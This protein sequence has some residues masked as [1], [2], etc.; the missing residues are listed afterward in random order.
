MTKTK[1]YLLIS[2]IF[3]VCTSQEKKTSLKNTTYGTAVVDEITSIYDGDTFRC[4]I[5]G[6]P[7]IVGE[8]I[9]IRIYGIDTPEM[10]DKN[11]KIKALAQKAKQFAVSKLRGAKVIELRNMRRGKFFRIVAEV[12]VDGKDLG[13]MM[14]KEGLA[15]E[16]YGGT[17]VVWQ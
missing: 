16:Y 4:N 3:I 11:P 15:K 10:R 12:W 17:K 9:G 2:L 14:I 6:Y 5:K 7:G 13:K 8:R 1:I